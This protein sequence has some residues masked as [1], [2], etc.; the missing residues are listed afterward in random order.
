VR[1]GHGRA[2]ASTGPCRAPQASPAGPLWPLGAG[3][4]IRMTQL[5]VL[6][7]LRPRGRTPGVQPPTPTPSARRGCAQA[8]VRLIIL[9]LPG[10]LPGS[11]CAPWWRRVLRRPARAAALRLPCAGAR[12]DPL[13]QPL[14]HDPAI[15]SSPGRPHKLL[16]QCAHG[17]PAP[18]GP[19]LP[20]PPPRRCLGVACCHADRRLCTRARSAVWPPPAPLNDCRGLIYGHLPPEQ[21]DCDSYPAP[22]ALRGPLCLEPRLC[23]CM[24]STIPTSAA[25]WRTLL[26]T[27]PPRRASHRTVAPPRSMARGARMHSARL[28][29]GQQLMRLPPG[30][31]PHVSAPTRQLRACAS[32]RELCRGVGLLR[33][34][35]TALPG[36]AA[37][38]GGS[39][40]IPAL[41]RSASA[42][43]ATACLW[44]QPLLPP[45]TLVHPHSGSCAPI[46]S[47]VPLSRRAAPA[48]APT[49]ASESG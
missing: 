8:Q 21:Y 39:R 37:R 43:R 12:G 11:A 9:F 29:P 18:F 4:W 44:P 28:Q 32:N 41:A 25:V 22:S 14:P 38:A 40:G 46:L 10:Q 31:T 17:A 33:P 49:T 15:F 47:S 3:T 13:S 7:P 48:L 5:A 23:I 36:G 20:A 26:N 42:S 6:Q 24:G 16:V 34:Q 1:G 27:N 30:W 45:A 35:R 19:S 2:P